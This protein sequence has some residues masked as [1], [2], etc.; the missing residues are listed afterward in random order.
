[1]SID[2]LGFRLPFELDAL[3]EV[4]LDTLLGGLLF[5]LGL[6]E[7]FDSTTLPPFLLVVFFRD[8]RSPRTAAVLSATLSPS[9]SRAFC[10]LQT[11]ATLS[12]SGS[13]AVSADFALWMSPFKLLSLLEVD[14]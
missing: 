3:L 7:V 9:G 6:F 8:F 10:S 12:T 14:R 4:L 5:A 13:L 2:F 1:M 11:A